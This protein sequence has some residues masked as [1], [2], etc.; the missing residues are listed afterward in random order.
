[1][2][3]TTVTDNYLFGNA[4]GVTVAEPVAGFVSGVVVNGN[5]IAGN[6]AG[7][8]DAITGS[9]DAENNWWGAVDGPSEGGGT[10]AA[11]SG[12]TITN[13]AGAAPDFTPFSIVS[14]CSAC[15]NDLY[16]DDSGSDAGN[17]CLVSGSPCETIQ[18]AVDVACPGATINVAAGT[19]DEQ[20]S[21]AKDLTVLGAGAGSAIVQP[22]SVAANTTSLTSAAPIAAIL[23][24]HSDATVDISGL[25]VDGADAA[26]N[27]CAPGYMGVYFRNASGSLATS[28]VTNIFHPSAGGCQSVVGVFVQSD[29][30]GTSTVT[31]EDNDIDVYGKNGVTCNEI[32]STC[33]IDGNTVTGRGPVLLGDAAQNGVQIGF[34]AGGSIVGN[35]IEDNYYS[36]MTFCSAGVLIGGSD[37][38]DV[39]SNTLDGNFCD[40]LAQTNG[41]LIA[42]NNIP[43]AGEFPF[44]ILGDNNVMDK[45]LV[46]G[47]PFDGVYNDGTG[48]T[49]TC[50]RIVDNAGN[51][52]YFDTFSGD[53]T[54]NTANQNVID[55]NGVG[56][57][58]TAVVVIPPIDAQNNYWGCAT[59]ANTGTCDTAVGNV[60]VTPHVASVPLCVTCAG[61]GGDLDNDGVCDPVDNCVATPNPGQANADGDALGDDCDACPND[62]DNDVDGDLVCGDDDNCPDVPNPGQTD[63][64]GDGEGDVCD[65]DDGDGTLVLSRV[66]LRADGTSTPTTGKVRVNALIADDTTGNFLPGNLTVDGDVRLELTAGLFTATI[67]FGTCTAQNP[68]KINCRNGSAKATFRLVP[69]RGN[70]FPNTWK[71]KAALN[72]VAD[73]DTPTGPATVLLI[74][75][76]PTIDRDDDI[77][78]CTARPG[79][80]SCRE[81]GS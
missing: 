25:T 78:A 30:P 67:E 10:G 17:F 34:G 11:G 27:A 72:G 55:G 15:S 26:F 16:V 18:H 52:F 63:T 68:K 74:Q 4:I 44:S 14:S 35:T 12:D 1:L 36:P 33:T 31:I 79:R 70:V 32:G 47:S 69:Q 56:L 38:V 48:N 76:T 75:P 3:N 62:P 42:G 2:S 80:L 54:P 22:G 9:V 8:V 60:D 21:M 61:A 7:L 46:D 57:D 23:L 39:L 66:V 5:C 51:G 49:Y 45:N 40:L 59:G 71:M 58:A 41:S 73:A 50:N 81:S 24:V 43:A 37:G 6:T 53:G 28:H 20:V 64:D 65:T 77:S 19:Y 29:A 13:T